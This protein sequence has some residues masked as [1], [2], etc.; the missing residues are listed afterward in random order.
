MRT[1]AVFLSGF[2]LTLAHLC[3]MFGLIQLLE[4]KSWGWLDLALVPVLLWT[5]YQL[6]VHTD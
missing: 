6:Y 3:L 5:S 1:F 2:S 4:G